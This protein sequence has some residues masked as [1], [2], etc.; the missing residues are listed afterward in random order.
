M[1]HV[2]HMIIKYLTYFMLN[3]WKLKNKQT[4]KETHNGSPLS[5]KKNE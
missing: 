3:K 2:H 1:K 4:K 5:I